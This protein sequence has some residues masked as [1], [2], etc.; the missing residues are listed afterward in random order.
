MAYSKEFLDEM[1]NAQDVFA[2]ETPSWE[3]AERGPK[4]YLWM[5]GVSAVLLL[6]AVFTA[7]YLFA[8]IILL[9]G[10]IIVLAGNEP[11][12]TVLVQV[13]HNG[14]V[15]NGQ[16]YQFGELLEFAIVYHPPHIK[17]LY[18]QPKSYVR[19][20]LRVSLEEQDP[21]EIRNHLKQYLQEDLDLREE[22][23]SDIIGRLLR[24]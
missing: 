13:G 16:L 3:H 18:L 2:W 8:L 4:W 12:R 9:V 11:P 1:I 24:M 19:P 17:V 5:A 20:R 22:H 6:Y 10:I 15:V 21:V 7:N 14:V 23:F